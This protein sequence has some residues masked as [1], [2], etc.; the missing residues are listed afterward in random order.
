[1][2]SVFIRLCFDI[3][4]KDKGRRRERKPFGVSRRVFMKK[5]GA[6]LSFDSIFGKKRKKKGKSLPVF[7]PSSPLSSLFDKR[8]GLSLSLSLFMVCFPPREYVKGALPKTRRRKIEGPATT[9]PP[10]WERL[11]RRRKKKGFRFRARR[12]LTSG[13]K[14][15]NPSSKSSWP[16]RSFLTRLTTSVVSYLSFAFEEREAKCANVVRRNFCKRGAISR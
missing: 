7:F 10:K 11:N 3:D 16:L 9:W 15:L 6:R 1:M 2:S 8:K 5:E 14:Q 4:P 13:K 12:S